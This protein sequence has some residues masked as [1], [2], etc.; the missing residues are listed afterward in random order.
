[1]NHASTADH[2]AKTLFDIVRPVK[3]ELDDSMRLLAKHMKNEVP[4]VDH[5]LQHGNLLS[6][7]RLRPLALLLVAGAV[8]RIDPRHKVLAA[9]IEM[10]HT[11]TLIHDDVLDESETRRHHQTIHE[12]W[13]VP[14]AVLLG[15]YL[16]SNAFFLASTTGCAEACLAIG[17]STNLVCEGEL[18]QVDSQSNFELSEDEY[19]QI[20]AGKTGRL[21]SCATR[22]GTFFQQGGQSE[23]RDESF[24]RAIG[25]QMEQYGANVGIAFQ[26]M[27]DVLD[28][29]GTG[30]KTGKTLRT[31]LLNQKPTLPVIRA[32]AEC[33]RQQKNELLNLLK[34]PSEDAQP[35]ILAVLQ[36]CG[37]IESSLATATTFAER[38]LRNLEGLE[39]SSYLHSLQMITRF[40]TTRN[41]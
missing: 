7:K 21:I 25:D 20:V 1:M 35:E 28:L 13:N 39:E 4:F 2:T 22:L 41:S 18:Q 14:T 24:D 10:I 11:A 23:S 19:L 12:K 38:A 31:D 37:A 40:L 8:G 30:Q 15:D 5:L 17:Q 32:L 16:F 6:G 34:N 9:A 33:E 36:D 27:D 29:V 3:S 26:I